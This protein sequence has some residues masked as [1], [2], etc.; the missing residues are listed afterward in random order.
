MFV[1]DRVP[2]EAEG[3]SLP[4]DV[5]VEDPGDPVCVT[6]PEHQLSSVFAIEGQASVY[7]VLCLSSGNREV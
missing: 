2:L 1:P 6:D 5:K 3:A 4:M 7:D